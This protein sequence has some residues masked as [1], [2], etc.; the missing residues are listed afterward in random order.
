MKYR[1]DHREMHSSIYCKYFELDISGF[2][3]YARQFVFIMHLIKSFVSDAGLI[4]FC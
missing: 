3:L 4:E 2:V 1:I